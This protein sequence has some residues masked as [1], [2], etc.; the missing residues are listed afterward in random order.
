MQDL[1]WAL[2]D[3]FIGDLIRSQLGTVV[4]LRGGWTLKSPRGK[5]MNG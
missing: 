2:K 5:R 4:E 3:A 1:F